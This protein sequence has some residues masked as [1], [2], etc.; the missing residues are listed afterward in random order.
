[1][2]CIQDGFGLHKAQDKDINIEAISVYTVIKVIDKGGCLG[3]K[4]NM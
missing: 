1:M 4:Y 2:Y 3:T